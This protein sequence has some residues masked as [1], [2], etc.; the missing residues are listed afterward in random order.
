MDTKNNF[1]VSVV[2]CTYN[3][4][5]YIREQIDSILQQTY[6]VD[7]IIIQDDCSTDGTCE[8]LYEYQQ[9]YAQKQVI[10]NK[11]NIG[12]NPNFFSA[13][14]RAKGDYI[15]IADQDDIWELD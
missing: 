5:K 3:G 8:V 14:A 13:I 11:R 1:T 10:R 6:S 2:M 4:E 9:R 12:F 7:E 15:A